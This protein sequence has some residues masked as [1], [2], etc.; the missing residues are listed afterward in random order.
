ML[1]HLYRQDKVSARHVSWTAY[2]QRFTFMVKYKSGVT[3]RVANALSWRKS[4][5]T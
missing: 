2:L 5:L 4:L 3:N 1:K